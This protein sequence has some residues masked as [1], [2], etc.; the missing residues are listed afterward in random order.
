MTATCSSVGDGWAEGGQRL[1]TYHRPAP[2]SSA[3]AGDFALIIQD[4]PALKMG[5]TTGDRAVRQP[6]LGGGG[7]PGPIDARAALR[8]NVIHSPIVRHRVGPGRVRQR[9]CC[10][11]RWTRTPAVPTGLTPGAVITAGTGTPPV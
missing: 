8:I 7:V 2:F 4:R 1:R 5:G 10:D 6:G 11:S 3:A 9:R